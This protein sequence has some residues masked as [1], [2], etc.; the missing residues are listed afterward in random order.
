[1][2]SLEKIVRLA[3]EGDRDIEDPRVPV[4]SQLLSKIR[5]LG[6]GTKY[7]ICVSSASSR[8]VHGLDRVGDVSHSGICHAYAHDGKCVSMLKTLYTNSCTHECAYCSNSPVCTSRRSHYSYEPEELARVTMGLYRRNFI[9]GLFLSSG[10]G[11]NEDSTMENMI[12]SVRILRTKYRF[13]GYIHLKIL[14]GVQKDHIAMAMSYA[15]RVSVNVEAPDSSHMGEISPTKEYATDIL[16]RQRWIDSLSKKISL[17]AG[18]TTQYVVGGAQE[19]DSDIFRS[20]CSEYED[21]K[22]K[23]AYFSSF[24]P[25]SGSPLEKRSAVPPWREHRLYQLDWLYRIYKIPKK[26]ICLIFDENGFIGNDD[27][28]RRLVSLTID[29][30]VDPNDAPY[31]TLLHIPGIGPTSARR[32][33]E[34]RKT[35]KITSVKN[36]H[37]LG[38]RTRNAVPYLQLNGWH[39]PRL[40]EWI[41]A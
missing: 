13:S 24:Y 11:S 10:I 16:R 36:L 2:V 25:V 41:D 28:K 7:D 31:N 33:V 20:M 5:T 32:I 9:E 29:K 17:P 39:T 37:D 38:V 40:E 6:E 12:E 18:H 22:L 1:M 23:R 15:D 35:K 21:Y 14:P 4:D 26:E 3:M 19:S 27:P 34:A 8:K 30:P